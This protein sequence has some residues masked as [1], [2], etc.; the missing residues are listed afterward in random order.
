MIFFKKPGNQCQAFFV[1]SQFQISLKSMETFLEKSI[2]YIISKPG[3]NPEKTC[4]VYPNRRAGVFLKKYYSELNS[5]TNWLPDLFAIQDFIFSITDLQKVDPVEISF[6]LYEIHLETEIDNRR[7]FEE[8]L[9]FTQLLINDINEIDF[10]NVNTSKLFGYLTES[11][12]IQL[13]NPEKSDLTEF[14]KSYLRFY[15]SLET[16]YNQ[17]KNKLLCNNKAYEGLAYR[18]FLEKLESGMINIPWDKVYFIGFNALNY[19]EQKITQMLELE[20]K[21]EM[22][23]DADVFYLYDNEHEAGLFLR[24]YLK[25]NT[26][27][28]WISN[29]FASENKKIEIM[30]IPGNGNQ[31]LLA[32]KL[33]QEEINHEIENLQNTAVVLADENLLLPFLNSLPESIQNVNITMGYPLKLISYYDFVIRYI[34]LHEHRISGNSKNQFLATDVISFIQHPV[35]IHHFSQSETINDIITSLRSYFFVSPKKLDEI[36]LHF[37]SI[38]KFINSYLD[39]SVSSVS[40]ILK[41]VISIIDTIKISKNISQKN[42]LESDMLYCIE[43]I[44]YQLNKYLQSFPYIETL[45]LLRKIFQQL[46]STSRLPFFGEPLAGLQVMGMLETR[47]LDYRNI[48]IVSVNE[49]TLPA[50]KNGN[51]LIPHD[52]R[53]DFGL[54]ITREKDAIFAYH[55]YRLLQRAEKITL[56]YN[57]EPDKMNGGDISRFILQLQDE[58]PRFNPSIK[59][60]HQIIESK[61][62]AEKQ[63]NKVF[64]TKNHEIINQLGKKAEYGLSPTS[65]SDYV[66]CPL[67]FYL[68]SLLYLKTD[69]QSDKTIDARIFGTIVHE[70]LQTIYT[71]FGNSP[72]TI[73]VLESINKERITALVKVLFEKNWPNGNIESGKN[74]LYFQMAVTQIMS[75][76][77]LEKEKIKQ[78]LSENQLLSIIGM[79]K[80]LNSNIELTNKSVS[81]VK[82]KGT[83]DRI[84]KLGNIFRLIDYKTGKVDQNKDLKIAVLDDIFT[85]SKLAKSLQLMIYCWLLA[86]NVTDHNFQCIPG[87]I[88]FKKIN[89]GLFNI[90]IDKDDLIVDNSVIQVFEEGFIRLL[91]EIFNPDIPFTQ[92]TNIENCSYCDYV[93]ICHR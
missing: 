2:Q 30:G 36:S 56:I 25:N 82:I 13:W 76:L 49:G 19:C 77:K 78:W 60:K 72:L 6:I 61:L 52:I 12:A 73:E 87:I 20:N 85:D 10:Y 4:F 80:E 34:Q 92:T 50:G 11:K 15:R 32:G 3:Y 31:V 27:E 63:I 23:W 5:N 44:I 46:V 43:L 86:K 68:K 74:L 57:S 84:D 33:I 48:I 88:S 38:N 42:T 93:N 37:L 54:P 40:Q 79:E 81:I 55:F 14:E 17:L 8:F 89:S 90:K 91:E 18:I 47:N 75:F 24:K 67:K 1:L 64:V 83:A 41:Q 51:S 65:L 26:T 69:E 62:S 28:R 35:F 66:Q 53:R 22:L 7:S 9:P 21:A 39:T 16:Y 58:L 71:E 59:I 45:T 29:Y 70:V